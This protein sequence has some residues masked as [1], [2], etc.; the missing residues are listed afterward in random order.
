MLVA[1]KKKLQGG[2]GHDCEFMLI[3]LEYGKML[4]ICHHSMLYVHD[5]NFRLKRYSWWDVKRSLT[6]LVLSAKTFQLTGPA[7]VH[8]IYI[9][10]QEN[11]G[12]VNSI[13][14]HLLAAS[15]KTCEQARRLRKAKVD[16]RYRWEGRETPARA[17][18]SSGRYHDTILQRHPK[19]QV[20]PIIK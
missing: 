7:P 14:Y 3:Q 11:S 15:S 16:T 9:H 6:V 2:S 17:P 8:D 19:V 20:I 13:T 1:G 4:R 5:T 10:T 12:S 18:V